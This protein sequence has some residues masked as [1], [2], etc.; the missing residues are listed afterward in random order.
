MKNKRVAVLCQAAAVPAIDGQRKPMK[1]GG[2]SDSGADIAFAL[3]TLDI[4]VLTP[5][6]RPDPRVDTDWVFPDTEA[7][8]ESAQALGA[9]VLW[10]NTV[11]FNGHPLQKTASADVS[12][13]GQSPSIVHRFDDKWYTNRLL[14][15]RGLNVARSVL[16]GHAAAPAN[17]IIDTSSLTAQNLRRR[18]LALPLVVKP[19]RGRGS[20]GVTRVRTLPELQSA[21]AGLL[22]ARTVEDGESHAKY[23]ELVILEEFLPGKEITLTVMPPGG[24][25]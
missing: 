2:Y 23:G 20:D 15:S 21:V 13:V 5:Q 16:V 19:R 11:L 3:K 24:Y 14:R 10:A 6:P 8:I 4:E 18:G 25:G 7:G 1:P 22:S 9:N 17:D 12:V